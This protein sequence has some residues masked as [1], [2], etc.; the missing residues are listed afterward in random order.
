VVRKQDKDHTRWS[1]GDEINFV[2]GLGTFSMSSQ[3]LPYMEY[4][5]RYIQ[6]NGGR[7]EPFAVA[8]VKHAQSKL[9]RCK[10]G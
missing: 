5:Y 7:D 8:G 4:L 6:A 10:K 3:P 1:T 2:N 9:Y